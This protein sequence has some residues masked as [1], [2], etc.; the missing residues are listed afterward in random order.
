MNCSFAS[1]IYIFRG[2]S[3]GSTRSRQRLAQGQALGAGWAGVKFSYSV[4]RQDNSECDAEDA[5]QGEQKE[6][7]GLEV[8]AFCGF[9]FREGCKTPGK[10]VECSREASVNRVASD[11][12]A[13]ALETPHVPDAVI[14]ETGLPHL[15]RN[16]RSRASNGMRTHL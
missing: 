16:G 13:A 11:V 12:A 3:A 15:R 6:N 8:R 1:A 2:A 10:F 7:S 9:L 5:W 14:R 4:K